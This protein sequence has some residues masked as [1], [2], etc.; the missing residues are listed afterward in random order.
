M[1]KRCF[2][3]LTLVNQLALIVML[4]T[5]I[6]VA[7]MAV[8]G[9]LVQGVQC[10]AHAIN[11]AGSLRMQSYRLLAVV[12]LDAKDQKLL[13]EMEQTAFSPE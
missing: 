10:S 5:A 13:D 11:K 12:P 6:G 4:S 3:P 1:F 7:G 9:W 8:S 2:S